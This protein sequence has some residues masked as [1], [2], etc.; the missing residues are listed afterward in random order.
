MRIKCQN[1][2]GMDK[3]KIILVTEISTEWQIADRFPDAIRYNI[4]ILVM[5]LWMDMVLKI[6]K[7]SLAKSK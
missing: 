6:K 4:I 7:Y 1:A 5:D 3:N 2:D